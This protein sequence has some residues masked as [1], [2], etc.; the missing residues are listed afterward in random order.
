MQP[1]IANPFLAVQNRTSGMP[2]SEISVA[3]WQ[4]IMPEYS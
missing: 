3:T 2:S 1:F 4:N